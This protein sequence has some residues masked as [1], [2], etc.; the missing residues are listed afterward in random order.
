MPN[1]NTTSEYSF[2]LGI[3]IYYFKWVAAHYIH[4]VQSHFYLILF[5]H[6]SS[7]LFLLHSFVLMSSLHATKKQQVTAF[8]ASRAF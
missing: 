8:I 7:I 3:K 6:P 4:R 5:Q 1:P 2:L